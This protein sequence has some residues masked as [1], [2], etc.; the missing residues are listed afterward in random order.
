MN[1]D[2]GRLDSVI[3]DYQAAIRLGRVSADTTRRR[4]GI[5]D[6]FQ[7]KNWLQKQLAQQQDRYEFEAARTVAVMHGF[8]P[9]D[10]PTRGSKKI[11][12]AFILI[13]LF[14]A[15]GVAILRK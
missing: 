10:R 11:I 14:L 1:A 5:I 6:V 12:L 9:A 4:P 15:T 7:Y 8:T 3:A 2:L 13:G